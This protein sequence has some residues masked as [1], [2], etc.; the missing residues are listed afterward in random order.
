M[1]GTSSKCEGV[2]ARA[3]EDP[4]MFDGIFLCNHL[5]GVLAEQ[6]GKLRFVLHV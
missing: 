2:T 1:L 5:N 4:V 6:L 3:G